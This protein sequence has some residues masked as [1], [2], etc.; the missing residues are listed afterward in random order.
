MKVKISILDDDGVSYEGEIQLKKNSKVVGKQIGK[1][2]QKGTI[3]SGSTNEKV[4]KLIEE[5][6]FNINRT[7]TEIVNELKTKDYH[8]KS[9]DLT[10]PLR[11]LVRSGRLKKTKE[12]PDN[13]KSKYWTYVKKNGN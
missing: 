8:F 9:A 4:I 3:R 13:K 10:M 7:I 1:T 6:F 2:R 11:T 12:L 5:N